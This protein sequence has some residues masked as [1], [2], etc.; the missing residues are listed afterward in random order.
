MALKAKRLQWCWVV[1]VN[2]QIHAS[3][4]LRIC[5]SGASP[6]LAR[7]NLLNPPP[8]PG[9]P[10]SQDPGQR[11]GFPGAGRAP[12]LQPSLTQALL[13]IFPETSRYRETSSSLQSFPKANILLAPQSHRAFS[14]GAHVPGSSELPVGRIFRLTSRWRADGPGNGYRPRAA[15][16]QLIQSWKGALVVK[17]FN[18]LSPMIISPGLELAN[19][20]PL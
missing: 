11:L 10:G 3:G 8:P 6:H 7:P 19:S 1:H 18:G 14:L 9:P 5:S 17:P 15:G 13:S 12:H 20:E 16:E 4:V 2:I